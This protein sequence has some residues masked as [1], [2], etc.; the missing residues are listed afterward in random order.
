MGQFEVWPL[1]TWQECLP[2]LSHR[3]ACSTSCL[4]FK[5]V[6]PQCP[7]GWAL[8]I[9]SHQKFHDTY[10]SD[11]NIMLPTSGRL[12]LRHRFA[13]HCVQPACDRLKTCHMLWQVVGPG[14][15]SHDVASRCK[16]A[17]IAGTIDTHHK[18]Q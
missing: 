5:L 12:D 4:Q 9:S 13:P 11:D 16:Y 18:Q 10:L 8:A 6:Q 7:N 2:L 3:Q 1:S 14:N 15:M 17:D